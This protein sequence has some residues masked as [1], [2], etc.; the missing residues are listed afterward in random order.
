MPDSRYLLESL[1]IARRIASLP[2]VEIRVWGESEARAFYDNAT[3]P[4][5]RFPFAGR[6]TFGAALIDLADPVNASLS[7]GGFKRLRQHS[8][9]A[10]LAGFTFAPFAPLEHLAR[11]LEI[12]ASAA[13]RQGRGMDPQYLDPAAVERMA[14]AHPLSFGVFGADG[15]LCAYAH[16]PVHGDVVVFS[17]IL[18]HAAFNELGVMYLLVSETNKHMA[19]RHAGTGA[20]RWSFY[21][22][23]LG[24][25]PGL[26]FFKD[27][28]G[29]EPRRVRWRWIGERAP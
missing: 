5:P 25:S 19:R 1:A 22:M 24:A 23:Y 20:P 16:A 29:F 8:R 2:P 6:K 11:I 18:G 14:R 9:K 12:N 27:R 28:C 17:R 4:H 3:A 13:I 26:R 15:D 10:S 7:G 21:D